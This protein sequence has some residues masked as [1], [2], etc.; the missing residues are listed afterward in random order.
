MYILKIN[1]YGEV[2]EAKGAPTGRIS[3]LF[4]SAIDTRA[5]KAIKFKKNKALR[6]LLSE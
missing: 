2:E 5:Y 3:H 1:R 6:T 4:F